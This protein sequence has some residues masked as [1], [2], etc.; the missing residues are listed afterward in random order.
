M[1]SRLIVSLGVTGL[2]L[3]AGCAGP[4]GEEEA[5]DVPPCDA[6]ALTE[7][8]VP[9]RG[10]ST[11]FFQTGGGDLYV[12]VTDLGENLLGEQRQTG[13][14]IGEGTVAPRT[15]D[16]GSNR[17]LGATESVTVRLDQLTRVAL[18]QG[19]YWLVSSNGGRV[20]LRTC[21]GV[22]VDVGATPG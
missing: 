7:L 6:P 9:F 21:P 11:A 2:L 14:D 17:V 22:E 10:V 19:S 18:P 3:V 4:G 16:D 5:G 15:V 1:P 20:S 12:G 8:G 13:V